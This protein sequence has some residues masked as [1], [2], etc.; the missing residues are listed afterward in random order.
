MPDFKQWDAERIANLR[1]LHSANG[2]DH[3]CAC[4]AEIDRLTRPADPRQQRE[5]D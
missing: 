2:A 5:G 4:Y 1:E 3:I